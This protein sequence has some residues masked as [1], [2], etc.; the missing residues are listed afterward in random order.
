MLSTSSVVIASNLAEILTDKGVRLVPKKNTLLEELTNSIKGKMGKLE[1]VD[2]DSIPDLIRIA[3]EGNELTVNGSK[4]Y[5]QSSHDTFMDNYI[6][7]LSQLVSGHISFA[8]KV[9]NKEINLIKEELEQ[10]LTSYKYKEPEDFFNVKYF[11]LCGVF[12]TP[13][14]STEISPYLETSKKYFFEQVSLSKLSE[15]GFDLKSYLLVGDTEDDEQITAWLAGIGD[16]LALS[17]LTT[18]IPEYTLSVD[19]LLDYALINFLFYRNL[20]VKRDIDLGLTSVGLTS[21]AIGNRDFFGFKL[22]V[23][24]SAYKKDIRNG[25]ILSTTSNT[26]FSYHGDNPVNIT[27]YEE[28]LA[29]LAEAGLSIEVLFGYISSGS[30]DN[31]VTVDTLIANGEEFVNKWMKTRSLYL[32]SLNNK[33]LDIF[34]QLLRTHFESSLH[35]VDIDAEEQEFL[36]SHTGFIEETKKLGNDYI[37]S[38]CPSDIDNLSDILLELVAKIRYRFT[39]AHYLLKNMSGILKTSPNTDPMEA[40]LFATVSYLTDYLIES[41]DTVNI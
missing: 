24:L 21:M 29:K 6:S 23:L 7:D 27:V 18:N 22:A 26:A 19:Q 2:K 9:V 32:I 30:G 37:D 1:I 10:S 16:E 31:D 13:I 25:R 36:T 17:Y 12:T 34:K 8:R 4:Q 20:S 14:I 5:Q 15:E 35:R 38:L 33:R 28:S 3:S 40:A 41:V 11:K 39:N